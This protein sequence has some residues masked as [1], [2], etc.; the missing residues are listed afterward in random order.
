MGESMSTTLFGK[1]SYATGCARV[2]L[3]RHPFARYASKVIMSWLGSHTGES[4][5]IAQW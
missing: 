2:V 3:E 5:P 1:S 4:A